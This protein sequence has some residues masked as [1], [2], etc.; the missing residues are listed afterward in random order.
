[1]DRNNVSK[2]LKDNKFSGWDSR[3]SRGDS[4]KR[5]LEVGSGHSIHLATWSLEEGSYHITGIGES[6]MAVVDRESG[7]QIQ[8]LSNNNLNI[9]T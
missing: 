5:F 9:T 4:S 3:E 2:S 8:N 6:L 7:I 1:M